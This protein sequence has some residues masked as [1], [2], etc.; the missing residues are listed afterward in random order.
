MKRL[1]YFPIFFLLLITACRKEVSTQFSDGNGGGG[2]IGADC[3]INKIVFKDSLS[4]IGLGSISAIINSLDKATDITVF[5]SLSLSLA[6]QITPQYFSDTIAIDPAQ[7]FI[8]DNTTKRIKFFHGLI[9]QTVPASQQFEVAYTYDASGYLINKRYKLV[10]LNIAFLQ[11]TYTYAAGNLVTMVMDDLFVMEI[12]RDATVTY[13]NTIAPKNYLYIFP[14]E[15]SYSL[16]TQ[17]YN[18][19]KKTTNAVKNLKVRYYNGG[20]PV[21]ST[22]STFQ[23]Y[24]MSRDNYVVSV[25]MAGDDQ[26]S[27]PA[28]E[29][30]LNF[31]Y[32]C[33]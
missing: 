10:P 3:R 33:K 17:F 9:D 5:D 15:D 18:F 25:Y 19:G 28:V 24:V 8:I 30:K 2:I 6:D 4:G 7:Y 13:Y 14:D 16:T 31:S 23:N 22:V 29:G 26:A 12:V 11:V 1:L 20:A 27:I 32:K 21:D